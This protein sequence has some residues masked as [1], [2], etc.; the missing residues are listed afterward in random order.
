VSRGCRAAQSPGQGR[1]GAAAV[2][3]TVAGRIRCRGRGSCVLSHRVERAGGRGGGCRGDQRER[4]TG[5]GRAQ[6]EKAE[7]GA[8]QKQTRSSSWRGA[9]WSLAE[10]KRR[11][12]LVRPLPVPPQLE[13]THTGE[14]GREQCHRGRLRGHGGGA[15]HVATRAAVVITR[16]A[17]VRVGT[18]PDPGLLPPVLSP[19]VN[20]VPPVLSGGVSASLEPPETAAM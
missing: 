9:R 18:G 8:R 20:G 1:P 15:T 2:S 7:A 3:G 13:A 11:L 10:A 14:P 12:L 17:G 5:W 4:D 6:S 19:G 16:V